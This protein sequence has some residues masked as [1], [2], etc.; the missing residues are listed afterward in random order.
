VLPQS[1]GISPMLTDTHLVLLSAAAQR[2]DGLLTPLEHLKGGARQ[3]CVTK[4][5]AQNLVLEVAVTRD[6]FAWREDADGSRLGLRMTS[7]GLRAIGLDPEPASD[8]EAGSTD[9]DGVEPA[10]DHSLQA[11]PAHAIRTEPRAG[12]K[13]ALI[14]AL[15]ARPEGASLADLT[16]ATGW[17]PHTA[18]AALTGLR[19]RGHAIARIKDASGISTYRL[20]QADPLEL[21]A[22]LTSS[23]G[24]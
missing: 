22:A 24:A 18:R 11:G 17:L 2:D 9:H 16:A 6:Q 3:K 5:L 1:D 10:G 8:A 13:Q 12:S 14:L 15:L 21:N 20:R 23:E 7:A 19:Q 4:L